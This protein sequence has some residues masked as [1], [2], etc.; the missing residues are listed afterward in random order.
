MTYKWIGAI[1][2]IAGCG[3]TGYAMAAQARQEEHLLRQLIASLTYMHGK[4]AYQLLPLPQLC[5]QTAAVSRG[6][7]RK[8]FT[9]LASQL[10]NQLYAQAAD[11]VDSA[12]SAVPE[13][14]KSMQQIIRELGHSLGQLDLSG[15]L[16]GLEEATAHC[17][18]KCAQLEQNR[19]QRIRSYQTLSLCAGA[20]LAILLL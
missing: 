8:L 14:P 20:A 15:Q 9:C 10:E 5:R 12:L 4:L 7:L 11:C 17:R 16:R 2:I 13:L 6:I 3:G 1:L 18:R 19:D